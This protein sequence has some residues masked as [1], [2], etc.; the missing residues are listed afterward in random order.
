MSNNIEIEAKV[1]LSRQDYKKVFDT[2]KTKIT[3]TH[4]QT[5]FYIDSKDRVLKK[6]DIALRIREYNRTYVLTCKTPLSEGLLEKNQ[7]LNE[8]VALEMINLNRF[9]SGGIQD[10]L[11]L[12]DIDVSNL[13]VL[14][15]LTTRRNELTID[16]SK[17][18]LDENTYG[19]KVD[20]EI[21]VE[22]SAMKLAEDRIEEI[23][24]PLGITYTLNKVSKQMRAIKAII[25]E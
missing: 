21:E 14:A 6:N 18:S 4:T 7:E 1:I 11:E 10:F 13:E 5:N 23:L 24:K 9:P 22:D 17:I 16:S 8:K 25:E 15:S 2:L 12:L 19:N 3:D 20:Y